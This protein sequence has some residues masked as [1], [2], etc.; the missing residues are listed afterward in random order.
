MKKLLLV[1]ISVLL[2]SVA[3]ASDS[4]LK[5]LGTLPNFEAID[6]NDAPFSSLSLEG[7]VSIINF[8]FTSCQGP[9]PVLMSKIKLVI[10]KSKSCKE[11][12]VISISVDPENDSPD[13]LNSYSQTRGFEESNWKLLRM[14]KEK[15]ID[16]I[17]NG[18]HLGQGDSVVNHT[19]RVVLV[20]KSLS[21]RALVRGMDNDSIDILSSGIQDLC[22]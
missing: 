4:T 8:F 7:K 22:K 18:V 1:L 6:Q 17:N 5:K 12:N 9:C 21:I 2:T 15:V 11:L 13:V 10:E 14:D 16:L 3:L 20:D 19:T